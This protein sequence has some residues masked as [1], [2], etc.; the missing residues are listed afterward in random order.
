VRGEQSRV[1]ELAF[2]FLK[3]AEEAGRLVEAGVAHRGLGLSCYYSGDF[4]EAQTHCERA[5]DAC[6]PERDQETRERFSDDTGILA[7]SCLAVTSWQLGEVERARRLIDEAIRRGKEL[8]HAPS[9]AHPLV[10]KSD[11]ELLRGDAAAALSAAE[12][13][14]CS[15]PGARDAV[16]AHEGRIECG[17][18]GRLSP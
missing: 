3:E 12:A 4:F 15:Q 5:L 17:V 9:M 8:G 11:L 2:P 10:R 16:L 1:R 13:L 7:M 18:G 6:D 14:R